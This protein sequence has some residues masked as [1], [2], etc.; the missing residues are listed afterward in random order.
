[1]IWD[2]RLAHG[3]APNDSDVPRIAQLVKGFR[4]EGAGRGRL[5][6]RARFIERALE[7]NGTSGVVSAL[8]RRVFALD[9]L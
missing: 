7:A 8:G 9:T 4:R 6:R 3:A 1:M 2:Q 5:R